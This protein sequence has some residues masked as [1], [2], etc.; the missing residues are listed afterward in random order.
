[1]REAL[2][3]A[4]E[5]R[6]ATLTWQAAHQLAEA[7]A[8]QAERPRAPGALPEEAYETARLAA[9]SIAWV[10]KRL[11]DEALRRSFLAWDR[12]QAAHAHRERLRRA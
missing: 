6:Y 2:R 12:V 8:G 4:R 11:P 1:M 9:E 7:L 5:I 3:V 10:A